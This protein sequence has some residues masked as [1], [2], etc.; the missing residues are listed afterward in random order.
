MTIRKFQVD[1]KPD[2]TGRLKLHYKI[3][4]K[5][6]NCYGIIKIKYERNIIKMSQLF[7]YQRKEQ[8]KKRP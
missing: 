6:C 5:Y 8:N 3:W 1:I 2:L 7:C 4:K